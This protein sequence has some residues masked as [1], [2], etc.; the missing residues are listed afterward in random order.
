MDYEI[1]NQIFERLSNN[2]NLFVAQQQNKDIMEV[3]NEML[4][5]KWLLPK[6][7]KPIT[8]VG[9]IT[10]SYLSGYEIS[11]EGNNEWDKI[12]DGFYK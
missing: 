4:K 7:L 6:Y 3:F 1:A 12:R 10:E 11:Y 9:G 8:Y 5:N 2:T